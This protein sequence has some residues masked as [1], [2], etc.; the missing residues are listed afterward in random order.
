MNGTPTLLCARN[1]AGETLSAWR[2][3][4]LPAEQ[5][6]GLDTHIASCPA[7]QARLA[8]YERVSQ[9]LRTQRTPRAEDF[10]W[11]DVRRLPTTRRTMRWGVVAPRGFSGVAALAAVLILALMSVAIFALHGR[12][13]KPTVSG[14]PTSVFVPSTE[15]G[16]N[17]ISL[18]SASEGWAMGSTVPDLTAR[19]ATP[20]QQTFVPSLVIMRLSGGRWSEVGTTLVGSPLSLS[21]DSANDGWAI[22]NETPWPVSSNGRVGVPAGLSG[23]ALLH[24]DGS[25]WRRLPMPGGANCTQVQMLAPNG[26]WMLCSGLNGTQAAG[27]LHYDGMAWA[28]QPLHLQVND[29]A[30]HRVAL[31]AFAMVSPTEGWAIGDTTPAETPNM[32]VILHYLNGRWSVHDIIHSAGLQSISLSSAQDGWAVGSVKS[33]DANIPGP[34]TPLLLHYNGAAWSAAQNPRADYYGAADGIQRVAMFSMHAGWLLL[35]SGLYGRD[36]PLSP[37]L[38]YDGAVWASS[39]LP[40][41]PSAEEW[42]IDGVTPASAGEAWAIGGRIRQ[43]LSRSNGQTQLADEAPLILHYQN[44]AWSVYSG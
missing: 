28:A 32:A 21:M 1:I 33:T 13:T 15:T 27:F 6:R 3:G 31:N 22:I 17:T 19:T 39:P 41:P 30:P 7:C 26:G 25:Q 9:A 43:S 35:Q 16:L 42:Q 12:P 24:Y 37:L 34:I 8:D 38:R 20:T 29:P 18:V 23:N 14:T 36:R 5:G 10:A 4:E 44:G 40:V 11:P 2:D